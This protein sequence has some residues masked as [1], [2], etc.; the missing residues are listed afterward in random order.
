MQY[1][2][3]FIVSADHVLPPG[4]DCIELSNQITGARLMLR[5]ALPEDGT[6][7]EA[8]IASVVADAPSLESVRPLF[9][10]M[11]SDWLDLLAFVMRSRFGID[12]ISRVIEW[13]PWMRERNLLAFEHFDPRYP[14]T[15]QLDSDFGATVEALANLPVRDY[16]VTALRH[17][18]RGVRAAQLEEQFQHFWLAIE[19]IA[20]SL[21]DRARVPIMCETHKQTAL[22]CPEC[23]T[24]PTRRR[25]SAQ[26]IRALL[27]QLLPPRIDAAKVYSQLSIARNKLLHGSTKHSVEVETGV[28]FYLIVERAGSIAW[29]AI[30]QTMGIPHTTNLLAFAEDEARLAHVTATAVPAILFGCPVD[31]MFPTDAQI[32]R[33]HFTISAQPSRERNTA[34][35]FHPTDTN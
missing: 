12:R 4:Q 35:I 24:P 2:A 20:T 28:E 33:P 8:L 11:L 3:D 26:A 30:F 10:E 32:P 5:N 18:R 1:R 15:H 25:P 6:T 9:E 13:D 34:C 31:T 16:A 27:Q 22:T 7:I 21:S 23:Q 29:T 17:F 19:G 14:P